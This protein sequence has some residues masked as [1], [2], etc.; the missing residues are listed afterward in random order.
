MCFYG[1]QQVLGR[2]FATRHCRLFVITVDVSIVTPKLQFLEPSLVTDQVLDHRC[3]VARAAVS[4]GCSGLDE[5]L[6]ATYKHWT[7]SSLLF[8]APETLA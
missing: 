4:S 8:S 2:V 7:S 1:S 3:C 5:R 6:L